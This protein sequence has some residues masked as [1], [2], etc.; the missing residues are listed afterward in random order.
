MRTNLLVQERSWQQGQGQSGN[1]RMLKTGWGNWI[2]D[3]K[4]V[5]TF[6]WHAPEFE[7]N[8]AAAPE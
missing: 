6:S 4:I 2:A 3:L 5:T 1:V 8:D 7:G